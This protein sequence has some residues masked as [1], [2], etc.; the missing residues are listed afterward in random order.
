MGTVHA[1]LDPEGRRV[2]L[3]L[4]HA[5]QADDDEFRSRF[6]REVELSRRVSG[7]CLVP[8]LAADTDAANP[9]LATEYISGPTLGHHITTSPRT[10]RSPVPA[11]T[12][13]RPVPR[14]P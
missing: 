8:L 4:I 6:R 7:P 1:A 3:K 2:A 14:R 10:A 13:L 9:W 12:L 5:A 11:C